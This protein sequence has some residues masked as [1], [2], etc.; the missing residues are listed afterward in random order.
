MSVF[1]DLYLD[2]A[3]LRLQRSLLEGRA[4]KLEY[5]NSITSIEFGFRIGSVFEF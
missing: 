1:V 4:F 5:D 2:L 3:T